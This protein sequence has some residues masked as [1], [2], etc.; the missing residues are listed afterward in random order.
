M[1]LGCRALGAAACG[2]CGDHYWEMT[3]LRYGTSV[4]ADAA[5]LEASGETDIAGERRF[6]VDVSE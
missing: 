6:R 3:E 5:C 4:I 2:G 1:G